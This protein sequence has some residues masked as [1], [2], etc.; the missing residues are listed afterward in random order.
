MKIL[1]SNQIPQH[2]K[3]MHKAILLAEKGRYAVSP[4][5]MV[6]A[7]VVQGE[8]CIAEGYHRAFG[9]EHA[10]VMALKKAGKQAK[11]ATLYVTLEPCASWG[12]TPPCV[13]TIIESKVKRVV[14]GMIDPNPINH[15][16]GIG[17]LKKAGVEVVWGIQSQFIEKQNES[18]V[19]HIKTGFPFVTLKMAQS[20]DG[21]I[22]CNT[23]SSRWI[24]S[25]ESREFVHRLR[26]EQ[27]GVMVGKNTLY[28]DNPRLSPVVTTPDKPRG[29]PWRIVLD[30]QGKI[31]KRAR[32]F[33][34]DQVTLCVV[35]KNYE[36]KKVKKKFPGVILPVA[37]KNKKI[38]LEE[39]FKKIGE[40]GIAKILVEGGGE[41]AWSLIKG[42]W[43]D[44]FYWI[45]A[46]KFVGG[47]T[48]KTSVE[49]EGINDLNAAINCRLTQIFYSGGD[50]IIEG[51]LK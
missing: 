25:P 22:A 1:T 19:K 9:L 31:S 4:N 7:C 23:G 14:I 6:G 49:G 15:R 30:P 26:A 18:F 3:W 8:K 46:P 37:V 41:F 35:A 38:Y 48:A 40:L 42:G 13:Q 32:I 33:E 34:G 36:N 27:D 47:R 11:G 2:Q 43:V 16:K 29:K 20:L 12:K 51:Y 39:M 5:P 44:K 17:A 24:S 45:M 50:V 21:K 28:L 10:E